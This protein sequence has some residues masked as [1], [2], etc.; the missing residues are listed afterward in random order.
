MNQACFRLMHE[1]GGRQMA[2]ASREGRRIVEDGIAMNEALR[3]NLFVTAVCVLNKIPV[4][5]VGKPGSSKTLTMQVLTSNMQGKQ[6]PSRCPAPWRSST[7]SSTPVGRG[8]RSSGTRASA[9]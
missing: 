8:P 7:G 5:L 6:S 3:E 9:R 4:F 1:D 2:A